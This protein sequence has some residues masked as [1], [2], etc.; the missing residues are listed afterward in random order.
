[1]TPLHYAAKENNGAVVRTLLAK[2]KDLYANDRQKLLQFVNAID[3]VSFLLLS[4]LNIIIE[5]KK[6]LYT[7]HLVQH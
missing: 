5:K 1:M 6:L 4:F 3:K 2:A 7:Q